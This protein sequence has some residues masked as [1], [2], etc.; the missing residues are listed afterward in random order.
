MTSLLRLLTLLLFSLSL[1]NGCGS[2]SSSSVSGSDSDTTSDS[3]T[4][5]DQD[6]DTDDT[7]DATLSGTFVFGSDTC[8]VFESDGMVTI[9]VLRTDDSGVFA[10]GHGI[11]GDGMLAAADGELGIPFGF[12]ERQ[13]VIFTA[14]S[15]NIRARSTE[16]AEGEESTDWYR[17]RLSIDFAANDGA[18][19]LAYLNLTHGKTEFR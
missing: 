9:T 10:L 8:S 3:D 13:R 4:D 7:P 12:W 16:V 17:V 5:T 2:S 15:T 11:N 19:T 6:S 1:L 14:N 18:G